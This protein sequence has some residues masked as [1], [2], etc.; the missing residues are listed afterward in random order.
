MG[1]GTETDG[2]VQSSPSSWLED[3]PE[4]CT[5]VQAGVVEEEARKACSPAFERS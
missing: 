2:P 5:H 3:M 4:A 1:L